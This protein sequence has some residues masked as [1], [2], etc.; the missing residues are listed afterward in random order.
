MEQTRY[1]PLGEP[2]LLCGGDMDITMPMVE[3]QLE[4]RPC[5]EGSLDSFSSLEFDMHDDLGHKV[6]E[7]FREMGGRFFILNRMMEQMHDSPPALRWSNTLDVGN[8]FYGALVM[9]TGV[10]ARPVI[11]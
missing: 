10:Q 7:Q 6:F 5:F 2:M 11:L 9:G 4:V 8:L 1:R 3:K